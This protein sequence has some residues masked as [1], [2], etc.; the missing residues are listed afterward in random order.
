MHFCESMET[1]GAKC[2][3][4][5]GYKLLEDGQNC[6]PESMSIFSFM[7]SPLN[8]VKSDSLFQDIFSLLAS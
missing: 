7:N 2:S 5:K 6:D 3:C 4:A 1:F 8:V